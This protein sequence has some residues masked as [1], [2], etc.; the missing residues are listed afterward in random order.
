MS[1]YDFDRFSQ[2]LRTI[3]QAKGTA[4]LPEIAEKLRMLLANPRFV[5]ATFSEETPPGKRVLL[6]DELTDAYVLAHVQ[7]PKKSG[8]PHSHGSSWAVYGN[9]RGYTDMTEWR[10]VNPP[11]EDHAELVA[12]QRYRLEEGEARAYAPNV[13]HS[14]AQPEKAWVIRV[15]G[16]DLDVLP[17][18]H[19]SPERDKIVEATAT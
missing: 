11:D 12:V 10:R 9:A 18:F 3:L 7:P 17:R 16:T 15:T 2:D 14:T 6:H 1:A 8:L 4:G 13:I 5:A 19:F